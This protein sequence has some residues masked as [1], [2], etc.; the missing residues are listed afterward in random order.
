M[1]QKELP[2]SVT[3]RKTRHW[4]RGEAARM[5]KAAIKESGMTQNRFCM[6]TGTPP[7]PPI[8]IMSGGDKIS[9]EMAVRIEEA[10]DLAAEGILVTQMNEQLRDAR[11]ARKGVERPEEVPE[12]SHRST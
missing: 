7:S 5:V 10:L 2:N 8:W 11:E 9:P 6:L 1:S 3:E 4:L 12:P